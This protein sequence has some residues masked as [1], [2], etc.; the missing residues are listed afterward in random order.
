MYY[1]FK[2]TFASGLLSKVCLLLHEAYFCNLTLASYHKP[3]WG[4]SHQE[5][6]AEKDKNTS[7]EETSKSAKAITLARGN[8]KAFQIGNDR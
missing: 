4:E 1:C 5:A 2:L 6:F 7:V 8:F 3:G